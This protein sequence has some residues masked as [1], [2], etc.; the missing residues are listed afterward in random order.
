MPHGN[1]ALEEPDRKA[2]EEELDRELEQTFP[3]SD[4]LKVTRSSPRTQ[5]TSTPH[6][7]EPKPDVD[8]DLLRVLMST[9][10]NRPSRSAGAATQ[11]SSPQDEPYVGR[12][13]WND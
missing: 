5:I 11:A 3:G 12:S 8:R 9:T 4:P 7:D 13:D 10:G 1:P 6:L 2:L